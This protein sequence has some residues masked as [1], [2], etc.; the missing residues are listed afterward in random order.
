MLEVCGVLPSGYDWIPASAGM[1]Q[2]DVSSGRVQ[3]SP[4]QGR[5]L[6]VQRDAAGVWGVPRFPLSSPKTG[7]S[8]GLMVRMEPALAGFASLCQ[9]CDWIPAPRFHEDKLRGNGG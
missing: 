3:D 6:T 5:S 4:L 8:R 9:R 7:G 2:E 1:T